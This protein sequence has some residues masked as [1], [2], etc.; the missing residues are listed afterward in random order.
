MSGDLACTVCILVCVQHDF[1]VIHPFKWINVL[2]KESSVKLNGESNH[3]LKIYIKQYCVHVT[4]Q[5]N[6]IILND[7][8]MR[9]ACPAHM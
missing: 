9:K 4:V 8:Q 7:N 3:A 1:K 2:L 6:T 5:S